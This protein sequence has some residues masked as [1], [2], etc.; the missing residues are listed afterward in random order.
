MLGGGSDVEELAVARGLAFKTSEVNET[1]QLIIAPHVCQHRL[2]RLVELLVIE[3][4]VLN[5]APERALTAHPH[6]RPPSFR[7]RLEIET[8]FAAAQDRAHVQKMVSNMTEGE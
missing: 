4:A 2:P 8:D 3:V 6:Q 5:C 7:Q 1:A